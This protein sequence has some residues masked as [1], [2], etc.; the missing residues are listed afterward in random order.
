[1]VGSPRITLRVPVEGRRRLE[2]AAESMNITLSECV[3][4]LLIAALEQRERQAV[5]KRAYPD[6]VAKVSDTYFLDT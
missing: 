2:R 5:L 1:M 3:R 4:R 6:K